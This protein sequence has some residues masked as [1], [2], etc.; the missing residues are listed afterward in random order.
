MDW[1]DWKPMFF[2]FAGTGIIVLGLIFGFRQAGT[3][4]DAKFWVFLTYSLIPVALGVLIM[5]AADI[6]DRLGN[7]NP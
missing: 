5:V 7:K 1:I 2:Q 3:A 4:D 6:A